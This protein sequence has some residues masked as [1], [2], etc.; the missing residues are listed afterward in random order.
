MA[1]I[2]D[3]TVFDGASTPETHTLK[4]ISVNTEKGVVKAHWREN[5]ASVPTEAQISATVSTK[6]LPSGVVQVDAVVNVPVMESI[7]GQNAAGYT[8]APKVAYVDQFKMTNFQHPRSTQTSRRLARQL[9]ANLLTNATTSVTV[10][11]SGPLPDAF[12]NQIM[13]S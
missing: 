7:S 5:L 6:R 13:P 3:I 8:A 12:D 4:A 11:T 1:S 2:A 10:S 9:M